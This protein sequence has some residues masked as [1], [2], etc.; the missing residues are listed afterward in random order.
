MFIPKTIYPWKSLFYYHIDTNKSD[1][2]QIKIY[3]PFVDSTFVW[4]KKI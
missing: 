3:L 2:N 1:Y 4:D